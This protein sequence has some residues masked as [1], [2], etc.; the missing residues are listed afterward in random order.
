MREHGTPHDVLLSLGHVT[1]QHR[2]S[3]GYHA[4][5]ATQSI[6]QN[7][8]PSHLSIMTSMKSVNLNYLNPVLLFIVSTVIF[9]ES[10][11]IYFFLTR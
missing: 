3:L 9:R 1:L 11:I 10:A 2:T 6:L 7:A 8:H 4:V 5:T